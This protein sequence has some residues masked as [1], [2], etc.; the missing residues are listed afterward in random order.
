MYPDPPLRRFTSRMLKFD[1][2]LC[3]LDVDLYAV[4]CYDVENQQGRVHHADHGRQAAGAAA[5]YQR[6]PE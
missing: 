3:K 4:M 5:V 2:I 6:V 1:T